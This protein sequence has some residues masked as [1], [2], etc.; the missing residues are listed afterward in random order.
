M[1]SQPCTTFSFQAEAEARIE[2]IIQETK[3]AIDKIKDAKP[4]EHLIHKLQERIYEEI[5]SVVDYLTDLI[6]G[7]VQGIMDAIES[8]IGEIMG[9]KVS[10]KSYG[11]IDVIHF[12][13]ILGIKVSKTE[14]IMYEADV[15]DM[16]FK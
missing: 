6:A 2:A 4:I 9:I 11:V 5:M 12:G 14:G 1:L 16:K 3:D 8:V 10:N 7:F 15:L 13:E